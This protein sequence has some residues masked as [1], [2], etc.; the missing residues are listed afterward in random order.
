METILHSLTYS[1]DFLDEQLADVTEQQ[2]VMRPDDSMNHPAWTLGHLSY[3]LNL[4]GTVIG[5][6]MSLSEDWAGVYGPGSQPVGDR[7]VYISKADALTVL[8]ASRD[9]LI[10]A[11]KRLD[12]AALDQPFPDPD[13]LDV[14]P[15][16]RHALTQVLV[17][18]TAFHVG[19]ISVWRK[20]MGL[21]GAKRSYE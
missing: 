21:P 5:L 15:T 14:F 10:E 20:A 1:I 2:M 17:G 6:E 16:V 12:D 18:H 4:I 7:S 19:Q 9:R 11:V 13:Y 8:R 3:T